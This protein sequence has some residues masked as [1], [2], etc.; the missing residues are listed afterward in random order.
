M[1]PMTQRDKMRELWQ[2]NAGNHEATIRAYA[3]AE[4]D[5]IVKRAKNASDLSPEDYAARLLAD[6]IKKGWLP[7]IAPKSP[8][9]PQTPRRAPAAGVTKPKYSRFVVYWWVAKSGPKL[10]RYATRHPGDIE[11]FSDTHFG[12]IARPLE[13]EDDD[14]K[15]ILRRMNGTWMVKSDQFDDK[16]VDYPFAFAETDGGAVWTDAQ[17]DELMVIQAV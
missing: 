9:P 4:R 3:Q 1:K 16:T 11:Q 12:I 14:L 17:D 15:L 6:G 13:P 2:A 10:C 5:G 8:S 7:R